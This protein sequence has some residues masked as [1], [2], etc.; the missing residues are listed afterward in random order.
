MM[1]REMGVMKAWEATVKKTQ[2]VA[3]KR[4]HSIIFGTWSE[5]QSEEDLLNIDDNGNDVQY[6]TYHS[7]KVF[8]NG[9]YYNGQCTDNFAHGQGKYLWTD[10]C[11]YVGEWC[12]GRPMGRGTF[13]WPSG[14]TYEG[15][16]T[17]GYM[18]GTGTFTASNGDTYKGKWVMNLKHGYGGKSFA[19][20]DFYEGEWRRGLQNGQGRYQWS[21]GNHY[22]GEWRNGSIWG[23]GSFVWADENR[24]DGLWEDGLPKGNGTYKWPDGSFYVGNWSK[25]PKEQN[26]T[27][28]PSAPSLEGDCHMDWDPQHLFQELNQCKVCPG[29]KVSVLPSLKKP[30]VWKAKKAAPPSRTTSGDGGAGAEKPSDADA[31][32]TDGE[33]SVDGTPTGGNELLE[34]LLGLHIEDFDGENQLQN[35]KAPK[36]AKRQGETISKGHKNYELMLNLQLGIRYFVMFCCNQVLFCFV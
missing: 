8:P 13:S 7:E 24:Y 27:Y 19:V 2:A 33:A 26:G 34:E 32:T 29:E 35:L 22:I 20:G 9:E 10:G 23:E 18:H 36:K 31:A 28:Y 16:F 4:A 25:D 17:N 1:G 15:H 6:E 12:K 11:V 5:A 21:N 14:A 30:A 3:K